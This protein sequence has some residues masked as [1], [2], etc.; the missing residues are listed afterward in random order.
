MSYYCNQSSLMS[1]DDATSIFMQ[2]YLLSIVIFFIVLQRFLYRGLFQYLPKR[3]CC[4]ARRVNSLADP[5]SD[6]SQIIALHDIY[7]YI[8]V[9]V[10]NNTV[11]YICTTSCFMF[12]SF[13]YI[14]FFEGDEYVHCAFGY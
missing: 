12:F 4:N 8:F 14:C 5:W 7:Q 6:I 13:L 11:L 3:C 2:E 9:Y 1:H 10:C